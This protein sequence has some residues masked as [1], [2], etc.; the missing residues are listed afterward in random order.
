MGKDFCPNVL[1]P[2]C[3]N[4]DRRNCNDGRWELIP[5]FRWWLTSW[6][7]LKGYPLR[8][9]LAGGWKNNFGTTSWTWLV[10]ERIFHLLK[11]SSISVN[12]LEWLRGEKTITYVQKTYVFT[13]DDDDCLFFQNWQL[14]RSRRVFGSAD[15]IACQEET[16][17]AMP[18]TMPLHAEVSIG[19]KQGARL[20]T[21]LCP[22]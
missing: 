13:R 14:A 15:F 16:I 4:I 6:S 8:P 21:G 5:V 20:R 11:S 9:R 17:F 12:H 2:F 18:F 10:C 1:Q 7:T 22:E 19:C 3:E